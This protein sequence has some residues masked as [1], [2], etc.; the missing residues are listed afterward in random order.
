MSL[1]SIA[2]EE[3][4]GAAD[5]SA[6][7]YT[8]EEWLFKEN[9]HKVVTEELAPTWKEAYT[10]DPSVHDPWYHMAMKKLGDL[11]ALRVYAPESIG[12]L[13][14]RLRAM[15][16]AVEEASRVSGGLGIHMMENPMYA[17]SMARACPAAFSKWG[18]KMLSGELIMAGAM[19]APEGSTNF[20]EQADIATFDES[21]QE[22]VLN[23]TKAFSSG[24]TLADIVRI[25][26]L[27]D[28]TLHFF[29]MERDTPGLTTHF[30]KELGNSP[31]SATFAMDNVRIPKEMDVAMPGVVD[32]KIVAPLGP[33]VFGFT[34]AAMALGTM[35]A[36][37]EETEEYLTHRS[38]YGAPILSLGQVQDQ[39]A[40][41]VAKVE[42]C[43]SMILVGADL[44]EGGA[45][46]AALYTSATKAFVCDTARQVTSDCVIKF[47]NPGIDPDTGIARHALDALG[48]SIGAGENDQH[49]SHLAHIMG[50]P[51]AK[52]VMP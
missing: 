1:L 46:E 24:G 44:I 14:M 37:V 36:A 19:T 9:V 50:Y 30:C 48:L 2:S 31:Y 25:A 17:I 8:E 12:G 41:L 26:G 23:G 28:G 51:N 47:G 10:E 7:G 22:W 27:C 35:E 43:R 29:F 49:Y 39:M 15:I 38:R 45:P 21:T 6:W 3:K 20:A 33:D 52:R 13:G 32:R 34:V 42:A 16:I 18:E 40:R 5:G 4:K 11:D